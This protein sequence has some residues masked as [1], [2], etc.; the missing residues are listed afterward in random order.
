MSTWAGRSPRQ[1]PR[2]PSGDPGGGLDCACGD[3]AGR[4]HRVPSSRLESGLV[5]S[6]ISGNLP[7]SILKILH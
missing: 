7:L 2:G 4:G 3:W 5:H 1:C 6:K